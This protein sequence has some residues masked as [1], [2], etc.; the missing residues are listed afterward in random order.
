MGPALSH[1]EALPGDRWLRQRPTVFGVAELPSD[2]IWWQPSDL[3]GGNL[4]AQ[5]NTEETL[6]MLRAISDECTAAYD[7]LRDGDDGRVLMDSGRWDGDFDDN[8][9]DDDDIDARDGDNVLRHFPVTRRV[10]Q[11]LDLCETALGHVSLY[12]LGP[13]HCHRDAFSDSNVSLRVEIVLF[14]CDPPN[15]T[16][17]AMA[18][19]GAAEEAAEAAETAALYV[20]LDRRPYRPGDVYVYDGTRIPQRR[21]AAVHEPLWLLVIDVWHPLLPSDARA[22]VTQR[23][24]PLRLPPPPPPTAGVSCDPPMVSPFVDAPLSSAASKATVTVHVAVVTTS[25][26]L[27]TASL[28]S[29]DRSLV[30]RWLAAPISDDGQIPPP[31]PSLSLPLQVAFFAHDA[32]TRSALRT[33]ASSAAT[34]DPVAGGCGVVC[35]D[36]TRGPVYAHIEVQLSRLVT[37]LG[38]DVVVVLVALHPSGGG[39]ERSAVAERVSRRFGRPTID[40]DVVDADGSGHAAVLATLASLLVAKWQAN[41]TWAALVDRAAQPPP[42]PKPP[43]EPRHPPPPPLPFCVVS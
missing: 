41:G 5:I 40:V 43:S 33:V 29:R 14:N 34:L 11:A 8:D 39:G 20:D 6:S 27:N 2:Q 42:V 12:R 28:L 9:N 7:R 16:A 32:S 10:L 35:F 38:D 36:A 4:L 25:S 18:T 24:P 3:V 1:N 13:G 37:Q 31:P 23:F 26:T 21:V 19:A 30:D 22:A 17:T 15:T